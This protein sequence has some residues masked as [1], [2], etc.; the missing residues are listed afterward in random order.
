MFTKISILRREKALRHAWNYVEWFHFGRRLPVC[1]C[2]YRKSLKVH[3]NLWDS[4]CF[5]PI[6][7]L[8]PGKLLIYRTWTHI[9]LSREAVPLLS[10]PEECVFLQLA[11]RN[12]YLH[13]HAEQ[14]LTWQISRLFFPLPGHMCIRRTSALLRYSW[15]IV[16]STYLSMQF[17]EFRHL[18]IPMRQSRR[19]WWWSHPSPLEASLCTCICNPSLTPVFSFPSCPPPPHCLEFHDGLILCMLFFC[20][21]SFT[22]HHHFIAASEIIF[23]IF[24]LLSVN[25]VNYIDWFF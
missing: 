3:G 11:V 23:F 15:H 5:V 10:F 19:S 25:M 18:C 16:N 6:W 2:L 1:L 22:H 8:L 14:N 4:D 20:L 21:T 24:L 9:R 12:T 17:D 7:C 13:Y